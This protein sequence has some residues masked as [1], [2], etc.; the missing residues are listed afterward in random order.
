[1]PTFTN[2]TVP[3]SEHA[4]VGV[5]DKGIGVHGTSNA[6]TRTGGVSDS[7]VG[8]HVDADHG[9]IQP[10][11]L[12]TTSSTPGHAMRASDATRAPGAMIGKAL[13]SLDAGRGMIPILAILQ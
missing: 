4:I 12:L 3:G 13:A 10:G 9:A 5:A 6:S 2:N 11:D 8:V 7:G 1:M